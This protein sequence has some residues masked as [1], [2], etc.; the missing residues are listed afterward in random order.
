MA[1]LVGH[2]IVEGRR[3]LR[4]IKMRALRDMFEGYGSNFRFDP[5]G[6]YSHE[7]ITVGDNVSLGLG[8][9]ILAAQSKILLGSDVMLGPNVT[10][11][12]GGHNISVIGRPMAKVHEKSGNEDLGVVI[13][14]DVW[15][16][17]GAMVLRGVTVSRGAIIAA[18][19]MVTKSP[20]P[21][22]IVGGNPAR[23]VRPR[24]TADQILEHERS[25]YPAERRLTA[26]QALAAAE[27]QEMCEPLR[28][29]PA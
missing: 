21:Y 2:M 24:W 28:S 4:R 13:E 12:G 10:I 9:T 3:G 17:A 6:I 5:D 8:C 18:G 25:V 1:R 27:R 14:D 20:P 15:I 29:K 7:N 26:Q 16:G 22:S 19:S 23:V 11:V